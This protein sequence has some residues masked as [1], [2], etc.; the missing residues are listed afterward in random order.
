ML[1]RREWDRA[2]TEQQVDS[3]LLDSAQFSMPHFGV[4]ENLTQPSTKT[5]GFS[6]AR[7]V[8]VSIWHSP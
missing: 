2:E 1:A 5:H 3:Q 4:R 8:A 7:S 6:H